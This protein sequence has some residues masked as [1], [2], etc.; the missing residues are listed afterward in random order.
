MFLCFLISIV[1]N[2]KTFSLAFA[3]DSST[4]PS[5]KLFF[6]NIMLSLVDLTKYN[7]LNEIVNSFDKNY[8]VLLALSTFSSSKPSNE[9]SDNLGIDPI[10]TEKTVFQTGVSIE[11]D[12]M[13][14]CFKMSKML[15]IQIN[16]PIHCIVIT[17]FLV[18]LI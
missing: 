13:C 15:K 1:L 5:R 11:V 17:G 3:L 10:E 18:P 8:S 12:Q 9:I 14:L 4:S 2:A 7:S 6:I 16:N